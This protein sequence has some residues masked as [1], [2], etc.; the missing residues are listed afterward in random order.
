VA[1]ICFDPDDRRAAS[2]EMFDR[3]ARSE[4]GRRMPRNVQEYRRALLEGDLERLRAVLPGTFMF[5]D[6]R[7][8]GGGR[9]ERVDD[10]IGW[11]AA[12]FE[13]SSDAIIEPLYYIAAEPHGVLAVGHTIGTLADGGEFESVFASLAIHQGDRVTGVELFELEDL[14]IARARFEELR[15]TGSPSASADGSTAG[16]AS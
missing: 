2:L 9:F 5:H 15:P 14:D 13:L 11:L 12:L 6:H 1:V 3:Y 16:G 8:T 10:Y 7:R 4:A